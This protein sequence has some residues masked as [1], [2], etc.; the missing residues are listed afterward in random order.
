LSRLCLFLPALF[1]V[2]LAGEEEPAPP[3]R[4]RDFSTLTIA[5]YNLCGADAD[6]K[7]V[8]QTIREADAD[9][10]AL[11]HVGEEAEAYLPTDLGSAY[12]FM[13]FRSNP[14]SHSVLQTASYAFLPKR[15]LW[16]VKHE[17]LAYRAGS[18]LLGRTNFGRTVVQLAN[19]ELHLSVAAQ[20]LH[21]RPFD[22]AVGVLRLRP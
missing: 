5:T 6:L 3:S 20:V 12:P 7:A 17:A 18:V 11:E 8:V 14:C 10:V 16:G 21:P 2:S 9:V 13:V 1:A 19:V 15:P 22:G 4:A